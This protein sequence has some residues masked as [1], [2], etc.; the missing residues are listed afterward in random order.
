MVTARIAAEEKLA[1][2]ELEA[3]AENTSSSESDDDPSSGLISSIKGNIKGKWRSVRKKEKKPVMSLRL[4][5]LLVYTVGIKCIGLKDLGIYS[6]EHIF[7][8]SESRAKREA[9]KEMVRHT[10]SCMVRVYPK[11]TRVNSTNYE[12]QM[13]WAMGAQVVAIN[14]QTFGGQRLLSSQLD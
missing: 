10:Q 6:P 11:G 13:Y 5:T 2:S 7:S 3:E 8:L 12:P 4:A 1:T 9:G 14:W